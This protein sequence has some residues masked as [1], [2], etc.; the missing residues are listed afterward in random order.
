MKRRFYLIFSFLLVLISFTVY[1]KEPLSY[2]Q[3]VEFEG[4]DKN[5]LYDAVSQTL[6]KIYS[7][8]K[9]AIQYQD[10]DSGTI[11]SNCHEKIK[12]NFM[13]MPTDF[14]MTINI[15]DGKIRIK[16][17]EIA[18]TATVGRASST[19]YITN[20]KALNDFKKE[21]DKIIASIIEGIK[22]KSVDDD[23]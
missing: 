20:E 21:G 2:Q 1:A 19:E 22:N 16:F 23:W 15:K 7:N 11:I 8:S 3:V 17:S 6:A 12:F 14:K 4:M 9:F 18:I 13:V 5:D 10:K